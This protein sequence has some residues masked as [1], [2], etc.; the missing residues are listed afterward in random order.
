MACTVL[1]LLGGIVK[2]DDCSELKRAMQSS[3]SDFKNDLGEPKSSGNYRAD[4]AL[5]GRDDCTVFAKRPRLSCGIRHERIGK[6]DAESAL[7]DLRQRVLACMS[8]IK[9]FEQKRD[10]RSFDS[11]GEALA[12][13]FVFPSGDMAYDIQIT[14]TASGNYDHK[15]GQYG[16]NV[17]IGRL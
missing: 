17:S 12:V 15:R 9:H 8:G 14:L 3:L 1:T 4:F 7:A 2:A 16:V 5:F 6:S 10:W 13:E 11:G